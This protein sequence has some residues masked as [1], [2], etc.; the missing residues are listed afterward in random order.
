[1][2]SSTAKTAQRIG[3]KQTPELN[4]LSREL[5]PGTVAAGIWS[6]KEKRGRFLKAIDL[7]NRGSAFVKGTPPQQPRTAAKT[8]S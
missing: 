6:I 5:L 2:A 7:G 8:I 3:N 4:V 1:L